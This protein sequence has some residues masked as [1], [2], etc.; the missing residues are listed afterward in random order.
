MKKKKLMKIRTMNIRKK[1]RRTMYSNIDWDKAA[2][3]F[4]QSSV[5]SQEDRE[6]ILSVR[7]LLPMIAAAGAIGLIFVCPPLGAAVGKFICEGKKY[8]GWRVRQSLD[9][10]KKQKYISATENEDGSITVRITKHGLPHALTY[11]LDTMQLNEPKK[12]DRKWR[13]IIFDIPNT[14]NRIRDVFR[15]RLEQLG[16][17]KLQESV[18]VSPYP[19]FDEVEFLR[20]LYDIAITVQYLLVEHIENDTE[21]KQK[22]NLIS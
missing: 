9:R 11:K 2:K 19:C 8:H 6:G 16:L 20:E 4:Q 5:A 17:R 21:L 10:L 3:A 18:Y 13:V 22:F 7:T 12:W 1:A 15:T 14:Y